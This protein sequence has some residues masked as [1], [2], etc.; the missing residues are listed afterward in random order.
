[1]TSRAPSP[2]WLSHR[3]AG[4]RA[5]GPAFADQRTVAAAERSRRVCASFHARSPNSLPS[6]FSRIERKERIFEGS[7]P[8]REKEY[9]WGGEFYDRDEF[10]YCSARVGGK[11]KKGREKR[12]EIREERI[13]SRSRAGFYFRMCFT[14]KRQTDVNLSLYAI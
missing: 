6:S 12:E 7:A 11:K 4:R 1:M 9:S 10:Y 8:S 3:Q 14:P 5:G 2:V 13:N